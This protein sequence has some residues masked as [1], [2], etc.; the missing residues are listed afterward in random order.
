[1]PDS[2]GFNGP[3]PTDPFSQFWFDM[4]SKMGA[5]AFTPPR[6]TS[7]TDDMM[8]QM[9]QAFF[10]SWAKYCEEFMRSEQFLSMMKKSM[11]GAL[12]FRTQLNEFM[13]KA[14]HE[15]QMPARSDTDSIL[16][17]LRS[18]EERVLD[19][20][21]RLSDRVANLETARTPSASEPPAAANDSK[22][23]PKEPAR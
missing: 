21:E 18:L 5:G 13:T 4:M 11:D 2:S 1:M 12:A 10:D 7:P 23:R 14:L 3:N 15:K 22:R 17:V 19:R 6:T 8:K 20:I 16:L 9:R